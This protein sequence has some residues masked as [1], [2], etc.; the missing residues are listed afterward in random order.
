M[1]DNMESYGMPNGFLDSLLDKPVDKV[2]MEEE[3]MRVV[4][5]DGSECELRAVGEPDPE[6]GRQRLKVRY[7]ASGDELAGML[8][9]K[10]NAADA[11]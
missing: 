2:V 11:G 4:F 8:G 3:R 10:L 5:V 1:S 6:T 7:S 9:V